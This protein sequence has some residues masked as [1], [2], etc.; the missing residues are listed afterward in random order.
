MFDVEITYDARE[1]GSKKVAALDM[2]GTLL[3]NYVINTAMGI[4]PEVENSTYCAHK[5][6]AGGLEDSMSHA[7]EIST[8]LDSVE[9]EDNL[10]DLEAYTKVIQELIEDRE[11]LD[12]AE[13]FVESLEAQGY[14][15]VVVSSAPKAFTV[16]YSEDLGISK[17][18]SWKDYL[19]QGQEFEGRYVD[20]GAGKG[21][22]EFIRALQNQGSDVM[23]IGDGGNDNLAASQADVSVMQDSWEVN[24]EQNFQTATR[25]VEL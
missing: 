6:D 18:Y 1:V 10:T 12:G 24:P 25:N 8:Y 15:T 13:E 23:F 4:D 3:S 16:P 5:S 19:F 14:E 22:Q 11:I 2:V 17:V 21:K 20:P 9:R 7:S